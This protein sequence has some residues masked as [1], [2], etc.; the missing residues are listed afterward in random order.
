MI[1][2]L[3]R[4]VGIELLGEPVSAEQGRWPRETR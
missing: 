3:A 4:Y 2:Q 1:A